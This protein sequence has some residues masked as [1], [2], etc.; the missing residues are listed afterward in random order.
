MSSEKNNE[1]QDSGIAAG[2][3][4]SSSEDQDSVIT[5]VKTPNRNTNSADLEDIRIKIKDLSAT[6]TSLC[7]MFNDSSPQN[8][9][10]QRPIHESTRAHS[11]SEPRFRENM[12]QIKLKDALAIVPEYNGRNLS[13]LQ[14]ARACKRAKELV[15]AASEPQLTRLLR[16]K[17]RDHAYLAVEDHTYYTVDDLT[18]RLKQVFTPAATPNYYRGELSKLAKRANEDILEYIGRTKD[19]RTAIID[20]EQ[21]TYPSVYLV[22]RES[23]EAMT[24]EAFINGLPPD[25][26]TQLSYHTYSTCEQAFDAAIVASRRVDIDKERFGPQ[27]PRNDYTAGIVCQICNRPNHTALECRNRINQTPQY[28]SNRN[29]YQNQ[30]TRYDNRN[31]YQ[32]RDPRS[33]YNNQGSQTTPS[34]FGRNQQNFQGQA[35]RDSRSF[36]QRPNATNINKYCRYCRKIGHNIEECR[37]R[38]YNNNARNTSD[39][40]DVVG[41]NNYNPVGDNTRK[42]PVVNNVQTESGN[43]TRLP[44]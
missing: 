42:N 17:L 36:P 20:A 40:N 33:N 25:I 43:E 12:S 1:N 13:V 8:D 21:N 7:G 6:L 30:F 35:Q 23:F 10:M 34:T 18:N 5:I 14:F 11:E 29:N 28:N 37:A 41:N 32:N 19:L 15:S 4:N 22:L 3:G 9:S 44:G 39:R 27:N 24:L 2:L 31:N 26:R 16:N 38:A